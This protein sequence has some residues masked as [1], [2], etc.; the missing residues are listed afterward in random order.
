MLELLIE[1]ISAPLVKANQAASMSASYTI[2]EANAMSAVEGTGGFREC[3][4]SAAAYEAFYTLLAC[5]LVVAAIRL[6]KDRTGRTKISDRKGL[7]FQDHRGIT[8]ATFSIPKQRQK[9]QWPTLLRT[10]AQSSSSSCSV[11]QPLESTTSSSSKSNTI[12]DNACTYKA[13]TSHWHP[14]HATFTQI[15]SDTLAT[16]VRA[17]RAAALPDLL[18]DARARASCQGIKGTMLQEFTE[19][20]LLTALRVCASRRCFHEALAAYDHVARHISGSGGG[21]QMWS[22]LLY[23][24]VETLAFSR[25]SVLCSM[26]ITNGTP[27]DNDFVNMVRFYANECDVAG[28]RRMMISL[29]AQDFQFDS[30]TRNRALS[31]CMKKNTTLHLAEVLAEEGLDPV[32]IVGYNI[33]MKGFAVTGKADR[34][35]QLYEELR[36]AGLS[37]TEVT[38]GI[39]L[40][41]CFDSGRI[42]RAV[43][44]FEALRNSGLDLNKVHYTT[45]IKGLANAGQFE[46]A[47]S[48]LEEMVRSQPATQPDLVTY[49]TLVKAFAERGKVMDA[50][51]VLEQMLLRGVSPDGV[52]FNIVLTGCC[53]SP[54]EPV[55]I[56]HVLH[57]LSRH[58]LKTSTTTM[59]IL[60]KALCL[61]HA[62]DEALEMLQSAPAKLGLLPEARL[63][64]QLAQA[65]AKARNGDK[66]LE[67]YG[68]LVRAVTSLGVQC[69]PA[70]SSRIFK[71]VT[72]STRNQDASK[73]QNALELY[74]TLLLHASA[75][76][77]RM[78]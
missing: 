16:A 19:L 73:L 55:Q 32:D 54:M 27:S 78:S 70:T 67:V 12:T 63:F 46:T 1:V 48:I 74:Q 45:F 42:D 64:A 38:F 3:G 8:S 51:R 7:P 11:K 26:L 56:A 69:D 65:C 30:V 39:L 20:C 25:C 58:G 77:A 41:I 10:I 71:L 52:I 29:R 49:S 4:F 47:L 44:T 68:A 2:K 62:W 53:V 66:V 31:V 15:E 50:I 60:V 13:T 37:P 28:L 76:A 24:A 33:L 17:G 40:D 5:G 43:A 14:C 34:C 18:D 57:W 72:T 21:G 9:E 22:L 36:T 35:F 61:N 23:S 6:L 75:S 59:S